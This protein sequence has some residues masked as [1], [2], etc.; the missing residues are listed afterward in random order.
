M[1][2]QGGGSLFRNGV[3]STRLQALVWIHFATVTMASHSFQS[4]SQ[5]NSS[6][7][8]LNIDCTPLF[9]GNFKSIVSHRS[10]PRLGHVM[11]FFLT[12]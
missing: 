6:L 1:R 10:L 5:E 2:R 8:G 12:L 9:S 11:F 4:E 7:S 3:C